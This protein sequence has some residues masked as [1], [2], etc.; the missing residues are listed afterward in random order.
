ML[1]CFSITFFQNKLVLL[2]GASPG[3]MKLELFSKDN[4]LVCV[5]DNDAA[6]LGSYPV[7]DGMRIHVSIKLFSNIIMLGPDPV[8][9]E[10]RLC[11]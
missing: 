7:D 11:P 6:L 9:G 3:T 1:L 10:M 4:K 2:T 5:L 8:K